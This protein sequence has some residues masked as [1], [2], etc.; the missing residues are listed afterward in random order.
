M[1][2]T[3][4]TSPVGMS[5][6]SGAGAFIVNLYTPGCTGPTKAVSSVWS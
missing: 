6:T 5:C 2:V 1:A 3:P 4:T